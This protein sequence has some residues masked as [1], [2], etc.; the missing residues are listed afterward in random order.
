LEV[1]FENELI[2][3]DLA[4]RAGFDATL[5]DPALSL[6]LFAPTNEAFQRDKGTIIEEM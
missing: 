3:A 6:T 1:A 2:T 5:N 4:V